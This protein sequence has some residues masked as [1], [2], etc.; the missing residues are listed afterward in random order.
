MNPSTMQ[1]SLA[2]DVTGGS[3]GLPQSPDDVGMPQAAPKVTPKGPSGI[4]GFLARNAENIGGVAGGLLGTAAAGALDVGTGG[5]ATV[6]DPTLVSGAAGLGEGLGQEIKNHYDPSQKTS[7]VKEG[8]IGAATQLGGDLAGKALAPI[9]KRGANLLHNYGIDV[10]SSVGGTLDKKT[11]RALDNRGTTEAMSNLGFGPK[12]FGDIA[13][14]VTGPDGLLNKIV[15]RG[16]G[17]AGK[18]DTTG[19]GDMAD[20]LVQQD[21]RIKDP[22]VENKALTFIKN[23]I[24]KINGVEDTN[25]APLSKTSAPGDILNKGADPNDTL[26][27]TRTLRREANQLTNNGKNPLSVTS[28]DA[29]V[30]NL[31]NHVADELEERLYT[32][33]KTSAGVVGAGADKVAA[34]GLVTDKDIADLKALSPGNKQWESFVDTKVKNGDTIG[35]LRSLQAPFVR[36]GKIASEKLAS[37]AGDSASKNALLK[38]GTL[39]GSVLAAP[40][41]HGASLAVPLAE[42]DAGK[43]IAAKGL[44][45]ASSLLDKSVTNNPR[46]TL[47]AKDFVNKTL[48]NTFPKL[49]SSSNGTAVKN[50]NGSQDITGG[51]VSSMLNNSVNQ[52]ANQVH[53]QLNTQQQQNPLLQQLTPDEIQ[54]ILNTSGIHGLEAIQGQQSEAL[55]IQKQEQP[56]LSGNQQDDITLGL[57]SLSSL[58]QLAPLWESA[59]SSG[60]GGGAAG[61]ASKIPFVGGSIANALAEGNKNSKSGS[62][63][64]TYMDNRYDLATNIAKLASNGGRTG[65]VS[66][67]QYIEEMLPT[68]SDS[69]QT[70]AEKFQRVAQ[71][72][73]SSLQNTLSTPA[74]NVPGALT[75]FSGQNI[76]G[77]D[78]NTA[79]QSANPYYSMGNE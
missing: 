67:T 46:G 30:A 14:K 11:A 43:T 18:V 26:N 72:I 68:L 61:V 69:P 57:N 78:V 63:Y 65:G 77:T 6:L 1:F 74:T 66:N 70:A 45:G 19:V 53:D 56:E 41:T 24:N 38:G 73:Q 55:A 39:V 32:D 2:P 27:F 23:G 8:A 33:G 58:Q 28:Q 25:A 35:K 44:Q 7:A 21:T 79:L 37:K 29:G 10:L 62:S 15:N 20:S 47:T 16:V 12:D 13:P 76:P 50:P 54:Q 9:A 52:I 3:G 64:I 71:V 51:P 49:F 59:V 48:L 60:A 31:Y 36:A 17:Q 42:T 40:V 5:L 75:N 4:G 22:S 34:N